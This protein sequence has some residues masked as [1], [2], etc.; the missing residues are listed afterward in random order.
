[1]E[2]LLR[3]IWIRHISA[4]LVAAALAQDANAA[5]TLLNPEGTLALG[6]NDDQRALKALRGVQ[7]KRLKYK[8]PGS[9]A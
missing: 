7:G 6:V 1:M 3:G 2:T 5:A 4:A 9:E 8:L